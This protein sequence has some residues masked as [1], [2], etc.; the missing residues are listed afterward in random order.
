MAVSR[1]FLSLISYCASLGTSFHQIC[2]CS[3]SMQQYKCIFL[4][5]WS[6]LKEWFEKNNCVHRS[7]L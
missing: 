6:F 4:I 2:F 7:E 1:P 3:L 5:L